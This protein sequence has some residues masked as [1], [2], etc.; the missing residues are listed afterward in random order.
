MSA[1]AGPPASPLRSWLQ[2]YLGTLYESA[3]LP[4]EADF[5]YLFYATFSENALI[6]HNHEI[7][8]L[9]VFLER[10]GVANFACTQAAVEW[11]ELIEIPQKENDSDSGPG[12]I[13]AGFFVVTRSL[14]FRIRAGPAQRQSLNSFTAK[15]EE[16][17]II[18]AEGRKE[19]GLRISQLFIT[20]VEKA[21]PV[22][23]RGAPAPFETANPSVLEKTSG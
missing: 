4:E 2:A 17:P 22:H 7:V 16:G 19:V 10:L 12:G 18:T 14:K 6:Y 15:V 13:I 8:S 21:V 3:P 20:S 23:L 1:D 5:R 9:E 11:K